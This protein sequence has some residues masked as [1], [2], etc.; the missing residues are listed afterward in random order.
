MAGSLDRRGFLKSA[1]VTGAAIGLGTSHSTALLAAEE[2]KPPLFKISLAEWSFHRMLRA[3][4]LDNLDF[5]PLA[6]NE[7]GIDC[8]EYVNVFFKDKARDKVYLSEL[9]KRCD[10]NGVRSGLIMCDAE[11]N[12]GDPDNA[13]RKEAVDNHHK[14]VEAAR[15]LGCHSIRV[16]ARSDAK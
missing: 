15:F 16:N 6:K 1:A 12:L 4:K 14:W 10:D 5:P 11:G 3:N 7:F 9:K 2:G 13:K 8:V